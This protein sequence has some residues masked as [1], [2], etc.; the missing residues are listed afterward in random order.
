MLP[1]TGNP[2]SIRLIKTG[3]RKVGGQLKRVGT[4]F[5]FSGDR[6]SIWDNNLILK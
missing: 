4:E 1:L 5:V 3:S 2:E 6:V